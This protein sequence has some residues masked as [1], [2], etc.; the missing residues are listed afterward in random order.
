[1]PNAPVAVCVGKLLAK[2]ISVFDVQ[3]VKLHG[4]K[5]SLTMVKN[6]W[7]GAEVLTFT[8][9]QYLMVFLILLVFG[10]VVIPIVFVQ[11]TLRKMS[12]WISKLKSSIREEGH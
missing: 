2:R 8:V 6:V 9:T 12:E 4:K 3:T 1:L 10:C 11:I 7:R 5:G